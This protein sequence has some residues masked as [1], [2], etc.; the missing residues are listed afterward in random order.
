[1]HC[2]FDSDFLLWKCFPFWWFAL[3]SG[4]KSNGTIAICFLPL[5]KHNEIAMSMRRAKLVRKKD[6][7]GHSVDPSFSYLEEAWWSHGSRDENKICFVVR[8]ES[9][10]YKHITSKIIEKRHQLEMVKKE[11]V[12]LYVFRV[13]FSLVLFL[14]LLPNYFST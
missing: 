7:I 13:Y 14:F 8:T 9:H 2:F 4:N 11:A 1:M 6:S 3:F 12:K 5:T 10:T